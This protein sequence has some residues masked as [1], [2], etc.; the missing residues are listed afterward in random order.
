[1]DPPAR[2]E[3][4]T[5]RDLRREFGGVQAVAGAS[6]RAE[7]GRITGLIGPNGAGKSTVLS[8]IAGA[9]KPSSGSITFRGLEIAGLAAHRVARR[10]VVRTFQISSEF[11]RL[12][13]LEN[14]LVAVPA[15]RG[16]S[17]GGAL[18]GKRWWRAQERRVDCVCS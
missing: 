8:M 13:V 14:L 11:T 6:F 15:Q 7:E 3:F 10:G 2:D 1:M 18:L 4:L 5:V 17:L 12:T 16:E 9:L